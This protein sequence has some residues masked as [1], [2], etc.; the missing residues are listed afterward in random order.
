MR[1][2]RKKRGGIGNYA[3]EELEK[4]KISGDEGNL[5]I[6]YNSGTT[7]TNDSNFFLYDIF[8]SMDRYQGHICSVHYT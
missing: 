8:R 2:N 7:F 5:L 3:K 1:R 6:Q 4:S